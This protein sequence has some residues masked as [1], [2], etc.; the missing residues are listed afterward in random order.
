MRANRFVTFVLAFLMASLLGRA[1]TLRLRAALRR[2]IR[3]E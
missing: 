2:D 1:G 3:Q